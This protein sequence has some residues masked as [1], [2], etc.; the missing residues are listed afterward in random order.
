MKT[1]FLQSQQVISII[2]KNIIISVTRLHLLRFIKK[3]KITFVERMSSPM[4]N[5]RSQEV[6]LNHSCKTFFI[7]YVLFHVVIM[8]IIK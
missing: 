1:V 6:L 8:K 7:F 3:K 5:S 2:V 4:L